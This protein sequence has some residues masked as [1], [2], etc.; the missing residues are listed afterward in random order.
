MRIYFF[1][2]IGL[3]FFL[4]FSCR[5]DEIIPPAEEEPTAEPVEDPHFSGFYLLN[6]GNMGMNLASLD[7][8]EYHTG[9]YYRDIYSER[10]PEVIKELGD[11]GN[12]LKVYGS[13]LYAVINGSNLIEVMDAKTTRH[14][15]AVNIPNCRYITFHEGKAYVSSFAG[16]VSSDPNVPLGIIAE[17]DTADFTV[18]RR[19]V[20]GYQP[21]QPAIANG[22]LYVPNSGGYKEPDFDRTVSVVD[23]ETFTEIKKIEVG[24][25][26][27]RTIVSKTGDI[28]VNSRGD[29]RTVSPRLHII[30]SQTDEVKQTLDIPVSNMYL[31]GDSLYYYGVEFNYYT[32]KNVISFGMLD[33]RTGEKISDNF[34]KDGTEKK[35]KMPYGLAVHPVT[36]EI[37]LTDAQ[38]YVVSGELYCFTPD[39]K[40]KWDVRCGNIP[41][42]I[43]FIKK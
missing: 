28:Y 20:V 6:E 25:N 13:K 24:L 7:Y 23:L 30:D 4:L 43:T 36:E 42:H 21:E 33:L 39:G 11:V 29:Y 3:F 22:K 12:D 26:P 32:A 1:L 38:N 41:A 40:K 5:E 16:P 15:T 2:L 8:F 27:H 37:Y 31:K 34:I 14:I 35:I 18:T 10:N 9:I 19:V 17:I